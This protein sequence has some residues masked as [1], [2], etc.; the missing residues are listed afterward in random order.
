[1]AGNGK[2]SFAD[3][4]GKSAAFNAPGGIAIDRNGYLYVADYLNNCIRKVAPGGEVRKIAGN[5]QKGFAD[6]PPSEAEFHYPFGIAVDHNGIVYVG[7]HFNHR[8]RKID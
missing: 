7:D 6:G 8:I 4:V 5:L 1:M 3:G 2:F